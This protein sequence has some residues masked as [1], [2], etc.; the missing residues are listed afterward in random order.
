MAAS[1]TARRNTRRASA[2]RSAED[3]ELLEGL[4]AGHESAFNLLYD[5]F[6]QRIYN[7]VYLRVRN[8]ADAEE[9]VQET[10]TAVFRCIESYGGRSTLSSW[11]YGIAKNT[12]NNHI[13]RQK[14]Q[15]A[16]LERAEPEV[17]HPTQSITTGSPEEQLN[18]RRYVESIRDRMGS[19]ADWQS[20]VFE[21]RHLEN[22]PIQEIARRTKRSNDAI[23]SSLYRMKRLLLEANEIGAGHEAR[24]AWS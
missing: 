17:L 12:V 3:N 19:V 7:F 23:R 6:F 4:R 22:L 18:L 24:G 16:R 1:Q 5:R 8:H 2:G 20:E 10:F 13:R 9:V 11:I 14:V 15:E 21:L